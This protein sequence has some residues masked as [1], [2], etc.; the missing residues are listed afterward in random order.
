MPTSMEVI[1]MMIP[2]VSNEML[3][4]MLQPIDPPK[5]GMT[6]DEQ[7]N[8]V[9]AILSRV[10][11]PALGVAYSD[12]GVNGGHVNP[13]N[14]THPLNSKW[15]MSRLFIVNAYMASHGTKDE[16]DFNAFEIEGQTIPN[17]CASA[18][19][20]AYL[21]GMATNAV[22]NTTAAMDVL[23]PAD[24]A[25][26]KTAWKQWGRVQS[27]TVHEVAAETENLLYA[28][29]GCM[30]MA[31]MSKDRMYMKFTMNA[32][33]G[34][35]MGVNSSIFQIAGTDTE[36]SI[37]ASTAAGK[38]RSCFTRSSDTDTGLHRRKLATDYEGRKE[39]I[40]YGVLGGDKERK[41]EIITPALQYARSRRNLDIVGSELYHPADETTVTG[42]Y[43]R[44]R[45]ESHAHPP[46]EDHNPCQRLIHLA[47]ICSVL[48][49]ITGGLTDQ[50]DKQVAQ[51]ID[52]ASVPWQ[53]TIAEK[54]FIMSMSLELRN[55]FRSL[56]DND[57]TIM[58]IRPNIEHNMLGVMMGR[59]GVE[60][61]GA[62]FWGQTELSVYD[63]GMH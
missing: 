24:N 13:G 42:L 58:L 6:S 10:L 62:T 32:T 25:A 15:K 41:R 57:F 37:A 18:N 49:S 45:S 33:G 39:N 5:T 23:T 38:R 20:S 29:R 12:T 47:K 60:D 59:G 44:T 7:E 36:A 54:Q 28:M 40:V 8:T 4:F 31:F 30:H 35:M 21:E 11:A 22:N 61:L 63:D 53:K 43:N 3:R 34:V 16:K 26:S 2:P 51:C 14:Q 19:Q 52:L 17:C 27:A 55:S 56:V 46:G 1:D 48:N 50:Y 9:N